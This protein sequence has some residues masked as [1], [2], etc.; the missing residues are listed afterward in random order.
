MTDWKILLLLD[1]GML[2]DEENELTSGGDNTIP[3]AKK[4]YSENV[5]LVNKDFTLHTETL[6]YNT[7][8]KIADI[9]GP[10]VL[11]QIA[12]IFTTRIGITRKQMI[13]NC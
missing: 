8:T 7:E 1:G 9:L 12:D 6:K 5:K 2:V 11:F 13:A 10:S 3:T 4:H